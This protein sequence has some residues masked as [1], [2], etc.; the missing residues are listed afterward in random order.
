LNVYAPL[1]HRPALT[2]SDFRPS[3]WQYLMGRDRT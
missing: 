3:H 2:G 1:R